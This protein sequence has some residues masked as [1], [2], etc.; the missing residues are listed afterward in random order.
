MYLDVLF[1]S[2]PA[3]PARIAHRVTVSIPDEPGDAPVTAVGG[4]IPVGAAEAIELV[5]PLRGDRW[6]VGD[7]CCRVIGPHR[8]TLLPLDGS[9]RVPEH[10]AIDF[11][12]PDASG[13]PYTRDKKVLANSP[14]YGVP[15]ISASL[16]RVVRVLDG[17]PDQVPGSLPEGATLQTAA[18][19]AS[20]AP[21]S[22]SSRRS[23]PASRCR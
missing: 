17:L 22:T 14:F 12:Q 13:R 20:W 3:V 6:L 18:G 5:P 16:G 7:G 8:F 15:V 21:C 11:V 9:L 10:F 1:A 4:R 19:D 2:R 23:V